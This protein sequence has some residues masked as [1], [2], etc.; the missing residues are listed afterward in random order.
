MKTFRCI[1]C[2]A[3]HSALVDDKKIPQLELDISNGDTIE[4]AA[5]SNNLNEQ[6][7]LLAYY[8]GQEIQYPDRIIDT[9]TQYRR[10]NLNEVNIKE[11]GSLSEKESEFYQDFYLKLRSA[12]ILSRKKIR[13]LKMTGNNQGRLVGAVMTSLDKMSNDEQVPNRDPEHREIVELYYGNRCCNDEVGELDGE[14]RALRAP[15]E[16]DKSE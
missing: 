13:A 5:I 2:N 3:K 12:A 1:T 7:V 9:A 16:G 4:D 8:I 11:L 14:P 6:K 15:E 10:M